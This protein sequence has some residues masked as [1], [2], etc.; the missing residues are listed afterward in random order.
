MSHIKLDEVK[1]ST[2]YNKRA[3]LSWQKFNSEMLS[4]V[5]FFE[6]NAYTII[7]SYIDPSF[8]RLVNPRYFSILHLKER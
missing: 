4:K 6:K 3:C 5:P 1:V 2:G 7:G 8:Q